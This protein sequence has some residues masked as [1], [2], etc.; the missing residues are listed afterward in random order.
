MRLLF[1]LN[2]FLQNMNIP[3]ALCGGSAIDLFIGHKTRPHKDLDVS[4]YWK[5]R[6]AIVESMLS[7][8]WLVFEPCGCEHLHRIYAPQAQKKI[9]SNIWCVFPTSKHYI[10][11]AHD[12]DLFAVEFDGLEQTE[13][14]YIE[15]LFNTQEDGCF[16]YA[17]N[18]AIE[19]AMD[20]S[21]LNAE[22]IPY[23][24]PELV[25]LYKASNLANPDYQLDFKNTLPLLDEERK[26]WLYDSICNVFGEEHEWALKLHAY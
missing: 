17:R 5:D 8:G 4:V 11:T 26:H 9:K 1:Q 15:F 25:L 16:L 22:G 6:D 14:D 2:D 13:L 18:T 19:R 23:L 10:F 20:K 7:M 12:N 24:A 3:Y 21:I